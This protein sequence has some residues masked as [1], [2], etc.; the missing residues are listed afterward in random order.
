MKRFGAL[1]AAIGLVL[2]VA[3]CS[4][5]PTATGSSTPSTSSSAA[6]PS[7]PASARSIDVGGDAVGIVDTSGGT[8]LYAYDQPVDGILAALA[9]ALGPQ[10]G[11][12]EWPGTNHTVPATVHAFGDVEVIENHYDAV[13]DHDILISP[14]WVFRTK[15]ASAGEVTIATADGVAVG[16]SV[17]DIPG[18]DDPDRLSTLAAEAGTSATILV[19]AST[20]SVLVPTG[21][22]SAVGVLAIAD[23]WPGQ[24]TSLTAPTQYGGA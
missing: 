3:G 5:A 23:P 21:S 19:E 1:V 16:S 22:S 7:V 6:T 24:I 15:T 9:A 14:V 20:G 4:G 10:T 18:H 13:V 8:T 2:T 17:A 12:S 11:S